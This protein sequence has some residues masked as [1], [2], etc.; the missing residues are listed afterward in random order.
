MLRV[1]NNKNILYI[2]KINNFQFLLNKLVKW[3][4]LYELNMVLNLFIITKKYNNYYIFARINFQRTRSKKPI[5][6]NNKWKFCF[7]KLILCKYKLK[8]IK[9]SDNFLFFEYINRLWGKQWYDEWYKIREKRFFF[10][11]L[12]HKSK[13]YVN[14]SI[15][16]YKYIIRNLKTDNKKKQKF[17]GNFNLGFTLLEFLYNVKKKNMYNNRLLKK[18]F[19]KFFIFRK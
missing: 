8:Y 18:K 11:N 5:N 17:L 6:F 19:S 13:V 15:L 12:L 14:F 1:K 3:K 9:I 10:K 4:I 16:Q 7:Y 2:Q